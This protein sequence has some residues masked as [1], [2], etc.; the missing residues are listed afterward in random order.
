MEIKEKQN[1]M[2]R[3]EEN[4]EDF[5][6]WTLIPTTYSEE[7][8]N[9]VTFKGETEEYIAAH[10]RIVNMMNKKGA[11]YCVNDREIRILD[12]PPKKPIKVEVKPLKG[13]SG[14]VNLKIYKVNG[15]GYATL[16]IQ[17][18]ANSDI[19]HVKVLAFKV[20]KYLLDGRID[21]EISDG[22]IEKM[23]QETTGKSEDVDLLCKICD[24]KFKTTQGLK[25]HRTK[26]HKNVSLK[27]DEESGGTCKKCKFV[28]A[29]Q[30]ELEKHA[31]SCGKE[32]INFVCDVC[33][34]VFQD[35]NRLNN[36]NRSVHNTQNYKCDY[37]DV[38]M[39]A[40]SDREAILVMQKHH[41][42]CICK[43]KVIDIQHKCSC[44]LCDYSSN[45]EDALKRH[46]RDMHDS[47]TK[48]ISPKPKKRRKLSNVE[49][50]E[51]DDHTK[52]EGVMIPDEFDHA[53]VMSSAD[54][55]VQPLN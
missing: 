7:N 27:I 12:N 36:H 9:G 24:K 51:T 47:S 43:P 19:L 52:E 44:D 18:T 3:F 8:K 13:P 16:M 25:I 41:D 32:R 20:V 42:V 4:I 39:E 5:Y 28:F 22:D 10:Q 1:D 48:S 14:K 53:T 46:K 34:E 45:D 55:K 37:C 49:D 38:M 50:M 29:N 21:G 33:G 31:L 11:K 17:K 54:E 6:E 26:I 35:S 15:N 40:E 23:K 30:E 2:E